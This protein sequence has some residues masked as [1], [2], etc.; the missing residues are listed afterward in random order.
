ML[1]LQAQGGGPQE[2][3]KWTAKYLRQHDDL[4]RVA[5]TLMELAFLPP[6]KALHVGKVHISITS[7]CDHDSAGSLVGGRKQQLIGKHQVGR[8]EGAGC[9]CMGLACVVCLVALHVCMPQ[10]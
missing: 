9:W 2:G 3:G 5:D 10:H 4:R 8:G 7:T 6:H 1:L